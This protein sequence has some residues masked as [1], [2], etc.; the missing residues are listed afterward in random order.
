MA[1]AQL[2]TIDESFPTFIDGRRRFPI[3]EVADAKPQLQIPQQTFRH[4]DS[5]R[6]IG[7]GDSRRRTRDHGWVLFSLAGPILIARLKRSFFSCR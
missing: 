7:N 5:R 2:E 4:G 1:A 6:R 3:F